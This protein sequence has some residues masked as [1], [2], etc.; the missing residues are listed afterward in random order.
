[1]ALL[2]APMQRL[3]VLSAA[4]LAPLATAKAQITISAYGGTALTVGSDV[5]L[6]LPGEPS[7]TYSGVPW[8]S[9][10]FT[11]PI[12][13][14]LRIAYWPDRESNFGVTL[15]FTHAKMLANDDS[16]L[17]AR[18]GD[19]DQDQ[20][21]LSDTYNYLAF[22]H[23]H[24]LVTLNV[25]GRLFPTG[26]RERSFLGRLQP[27]AGLG[28]GVAIPH[29]EVDLVDGSVTNEYQLAGVALQGLAGASFDVI[30]RLAAFI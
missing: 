9:E 2:I 25:F 10:S 4:L 3:L 16:V 13:Y 24:N 5:R 20:E 30:S 6:E 19:T 28:L 29:V 1:M 26:A 17:V 8:R 22:S 12:Y 27:Y 21:L 15:D 11:S 14:G 18:E 23:G 7:T